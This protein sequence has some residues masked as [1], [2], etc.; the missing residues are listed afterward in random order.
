MMMM[1]II[2]QE[3]CG[4]LFSFTILHILRFSFPFLFLYYSSVEYLL[5]YISVNKP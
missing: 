4:F 5:V 1:M 2:F 3:F